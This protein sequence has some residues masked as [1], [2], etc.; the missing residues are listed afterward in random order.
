[1]SDPFASLPE[2]ELVDIRHED[3]ARAALD[4]FGR[5]LW[6]EALRYLYEDAAERPL[7]RVTHLPVPLLQI[8][9]RP[10]GPP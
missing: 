6:D 5:A 9:L 2:P 1:M 4:R 3:V 10:A 8:R 7:R